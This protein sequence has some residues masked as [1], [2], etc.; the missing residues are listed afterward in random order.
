MTDHKKQEKPL[1]QPTPEQNDILQAFFATAKDQ[2]NLVP[3]L[4]LADKAYDPMKGLQQY[5]DEKAQRKRRVEIAMAKLGLP[6][7]PVMERMN[8]SPEQAIMHSRR[9]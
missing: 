8:M 7:T 5:S 2:K 4:G 6:N 9:F 1:P 3:G